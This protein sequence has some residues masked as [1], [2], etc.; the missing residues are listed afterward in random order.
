M[1]RDDALRLLHVVDFIYDWGRDIY[2]SNVLRCLENPGWGLRGVTPSDSRIDSLAD[3]AE[4]S[5]VPTVHTNRVEGGFIMS[6]PKQLL[7]HLIPGKKDPVKESKRK[8]DILEGIQKVPAIIWRWQIDALPYPS[9]A[10]ILTLKPHI[11]YYFTN[12]HITDERIESLLDDLYPPSDRTN[13]ARTLLQLFNEKTC[14]ADWDIICRLENYWTREPHS[15]CSDIH[16]LPSKEKLFSRIFIKTFFYTESWTIV[17]QLNCLTA[18][19]SALEKMRSISD[20]ITPAAV[21]EEYI[22]RVPHQDLEHTLAKFR[23]WNFWSVTAAMLQLHWELDGPKSLYPDEEG[24]LPA[25]WDGSIESESNPGDGCHELKLWIKDTYEE[26]TWRPADFFASA[27]L[28]I[29]DPDTDSKF[30]RTSTLSV[31]APSSVEDTPALFKLPK[32]LE[33]LLE[34]GNILLRNKSQP[35]PPLGRYCLLLVDRE[36]CMQKNRLIGKGMYWSRF[37]T[38]RDRGKVEPRGW[39]ESAAITLKIWESYVPYTLELLALEL[40]EGNCMSP[41]ILDSVGAHFLPS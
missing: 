20:S 21:K 3:S 16:L 9:A 17:K 7:V 15:H 31:A 35:G 30:F 23:T 10:R 40:E 38:K 11:Q 27:G 22:W 28:K 41:S 26:E 25:S 29:P 24:Y 5:L 2:R 32:P 1:D 4:V 13:G 36:R 12:L 18:S 19:A 34:N 8:L 39:S 14:I 33:S 37:G 6:Y